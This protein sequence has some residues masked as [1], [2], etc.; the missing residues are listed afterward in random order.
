MF[1]KV[2][3][4]H[5]LLKCL[6]LRPLLLSSLLLLFLRFTPRVWNARWGKT[7]VDVHGKNG[8]MGG[9]D[10][11]GVP[12]EGGHHCC[13]SHK[14]ATV[15]TSFYGGGA[16]RVSPSALIDNTTRKGSVCYAFDPGLALL[17]I[18]A[19]DTLQEHGPPTS[20]RSN[21]ESHGV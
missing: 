11:N 14:A 9:I 7:D 20:A 18:S 21:R 16:L 6:L 5:A 17:R 15:L 10:T 8:A 4:L 19:I 1:Q 12:E 2:T 3:R 13:A